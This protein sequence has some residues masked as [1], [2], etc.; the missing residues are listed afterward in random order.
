VQQFTLNLSHLCNNRHHKNLNSNKT[1]VTL[2]LN[3]L[4]GLG[5][6]QQRLIAHTTTLKITILIIAIFT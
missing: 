6:F 5:T 4:P 1:S 2:D 3:I